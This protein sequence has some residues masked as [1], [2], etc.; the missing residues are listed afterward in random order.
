L[1]VDYTQPTP[2]IKLA[3]QIAF[4]ST[5]ELGQVQDFISHLLIGTNREIGDITG[6]GS[7]DIQDLSIL[8][9]DWLRGNSMADIAPPPDGDG[10][11]NLNDYAIMAENWMITIDN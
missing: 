2:T 3:G 11:V 4:D 6:D 5:S 8:M 1:R 9:N 7:V 10:I